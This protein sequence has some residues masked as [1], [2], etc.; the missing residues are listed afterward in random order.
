[1]SQNS[2][3]TSITDIVRN[4][5]D[6][7]RQLIPFFKEVHLPHA[8]PDA[9]DA[10]DETTEILHK[11]LVTEM[12]RYGLPQEA[13]DSFSLPIYE[14]FYSSFFGTSVIEVVPIGSKLSV[15]ENVLVFSRFTTQINDLDSVE[16]LTASKDLKIVEV[17]DPV[18]LPYASVEFRLRHFFEGETKLIEDLI[19]DENKNYSKVKRAYLTN[20][21]G[22]VIK[23]IT[24]KRVKPVIPNVGFDKRITPPSEEDLKHLKQLYKK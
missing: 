21:K 9:Y 20:D 4:F 3:E 11:H 2:W 13:M 7:L 16:A 12:I 19:I 23:D 14:A 8:L 15:N 22:E 6:A 10:W 17:N 1:M 5:H 18:S 24:E